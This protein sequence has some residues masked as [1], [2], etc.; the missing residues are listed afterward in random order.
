MAAPRERLRMRAASAKKAARGVDAP[1]L[2]DVGARFESGRGAWRLQMRLKL[3]ITFNECLVNVFL[4]KRI[5]CFFSRLCD[6][7]ADTAT[8]SRVFQH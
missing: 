1:W 5:Y 2:R 4:Q 6:F 7:L 8:W 3:T